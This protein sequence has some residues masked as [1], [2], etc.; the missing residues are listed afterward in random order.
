MV[1]RKMHGVYHL[2][3]GEPISWYDY[4][5]LIFELADFRR[6]CKPPTSANIEQPHAGRNFRR[7]RTASL[8]RTAS[9]PCPS[10]AKLFARIY[11][12]AKTLLLIVLRSVVTRACLY[13]VVGVIGF[14]FNAPEPAVPSG[15]L[16]CSRLNI[17]CAVLPESV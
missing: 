17:D 10:F 4:A 5:K 13:F 1:E 6:S 11:R 15:L 16:G 8:R 12:L 3:G 7:F 2:G 14:N 9:R